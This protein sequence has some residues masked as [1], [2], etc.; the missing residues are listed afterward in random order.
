[1]Y[2]VVLFNFEG[3]FGFLNHG[4]IEGFVNEII[5][6]EMFLPPTTKRRRK[7][8]RFVQTLFCLN[9]R[10]GNPGLLNNNIFLVVG[11]FFYKP[12]YQAEE[13]SF[14]LESLPKL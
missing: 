8:F 11:A 14:R 7:L 4:E 9:C 10:I 6:F 12:D 13:I 3:L 5:Y 2:Y 1:M